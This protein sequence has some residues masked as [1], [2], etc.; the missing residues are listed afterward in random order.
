MLAT[1]TFGIIVLMVNG[2]L[3]LANVHGMPTDSGLNNRPIIAILSQEISKDLLPPE[4]KAKSYIAASYVKYIESAG[5][6]V[7][8]ITT[9]MS[10]Q[11]I[12]DVFNSVN[13]VLFPGGAVNLSDSQYFKNAKH[14]F[15]LAM[16]A[17]A[18]EDFF[19]IWGTCLG[20]EALAN[21]V[22]GE[23]V[24]SGSNSTAIAL[25]LNF[26]GC[27]KCSK[28]M[29]DAPDQLVKKLSTEALTYNYHE[30]C[31]TPEIF[32]ATKVLDRMLRVVSYNT[33][34]KGKVFISTFEG[35]LPGGVTRACF[36]RG[37]SASSKIHPKG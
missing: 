9:S 18:R 16:A 34:K 31:V 19:P 24:L 23:N 7:V 32:V 11:E 30:K 12:E 10:Y 15:N 4:V 25:P 20:F 1:R 2:Y 5:A 27:A 35:K 26:S 29:R 28:M 22:A 33:D 36:I 8:P 3:E 6:R 17:K 37:P 14:F 13:G 21:I